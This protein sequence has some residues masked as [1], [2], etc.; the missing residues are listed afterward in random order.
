[1][2]RYVRVGADV[3]HI[4]GETSIPGPN[5]DSPFRWHLHPRQVQCL[6][7]ATFAGRLLLRDK[8]LRLIGLNPRLDLLCNEISRCA[9]RKR[10]LNQALRPLVLLRHVQQ[11]RRY[12][13]FAAGSDTFL[14]GDELLRGLRR[15][16]RHAQLP[17]DCVSR[18][19][20]RQPAAHQ[21]QRDALF[22]CDLRQ[23]RRHV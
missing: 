5:A 23:V 4:D 8:P 15:Y 6:C 17:L 9:Q 11:L 7:Q 22:L 1:M 19:P 16:A 14:L 2:V 10:A 3:E 13:D 12:G 18:E 20:E 21:V